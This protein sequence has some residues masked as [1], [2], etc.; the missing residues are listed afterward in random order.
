MG[1]VMKPLFGLLQMFNIRKEQ[2]VQAGEYDESYTSFDDFPADSAFDPLQAR[3][4]PS[5]LNC[6]SLTTR[7]WFAIT[8]ENL[9]DVEWSTSSLEHLVAPENV[10]DMIIKLV[11]QHRNQEREGVVGDVIHGKGNVCPFADL[12]KIFRSF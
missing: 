7:K 1:D 5:S 8:I 6:F 12:I 2:P 3:L 4:S 9:K 10:K 11:Q